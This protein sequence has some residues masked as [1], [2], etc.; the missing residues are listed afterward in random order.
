MRQMQLCA[1]GI[2]LDAARR[3]ALVQRANPPSAGTWSVPGG[4]CGPDESPEQACVREVAEE[5]GLSVEV[6]RHAGQVSREGPGGV[7]YLIDDYV[8][9]VVGG[10][11]TAGD[12]AADVRWVTRKDLADLEL[13]PGLYD[14]LAGWDLLPD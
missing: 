11:L 14:A 4:R 5:T 10:V 13:A 7:T 2:V 6:E 3:L 1:G 8:C 12:D 9:R